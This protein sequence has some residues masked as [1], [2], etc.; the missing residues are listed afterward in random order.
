MR[1][2]TV[3]AELWA[4]LLAALH[5]DDPNVRAAA[6][7]RLVRRGEQMGWDPAWTPEQAR[8]AVEVAR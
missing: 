1:Y 3:S 4:L 5:S 2:T 8:R 7:D 6:R